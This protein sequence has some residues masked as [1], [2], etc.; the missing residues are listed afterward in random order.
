MVTK[1]G[2]ATILRIREAV[3]EDL[4]PITAIYND[5]ILNT[6]ATFDTE[7][8]RVEDQQGWFAS[9]GGKYPLLIADLDHRVVGW[10]SLSRWSDRCA[11]SDTAEL[12]VYVHEAHRGR[13]IGKALI[14]AVIREGQTRGLHT[15][16]ARIAEGNA[17]S[18]RLHESV[19]FHHIGT[20]R[21][22]GSKFGKRLDVQLMQLIFEN[23]STPDQGTSTSQSHA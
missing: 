14:R 13:G 21:E 10:A 22:V 8:K 17:I 19:G 23:A 7:L 2:G 5:A 1:A 20:M 15:I 9:H 11:Y 12:S 6:V 3:Q 4:A 18:V 16:L